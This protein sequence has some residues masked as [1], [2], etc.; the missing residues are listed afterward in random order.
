[1]HVIDDLTAGREAYA[2]RA[3][4]A[5]RDLLSRADP[6]RLEPDDLR[7][8]STAAYL[9]GD[10]GL[11]VRSRQRAHSASIALGEHLAAARDAHDI[12]MVLAMNGEPA[13]A[14][15]W[16]ARAERLLRDEPEDS[17]ER[18]FLLM[19]Q[20]LRYLQAGDLAHLVSCCARIEE[21]G[22]H[23]DNPDLVT[24]ALSAT[25]RA[26]LYA[27]KVPDGL[28]RLDEAM[29][30]LTSDQVSPLMAGQVY[31]TMIEGCQEIADYRRMTEWTEALTQW[32][33]DQPDLV[34][35]TGQCAVHRGQIHRSHG[36]FQAALDELALALDRYAAAGMGP[37][38]GLVHY[39]RGEVLRTLGDLDGAQSAFDDA[40]D[41]GLEPQPGQSLLWLARGRTDAAVS[42][43]HRLLEDAHDP[44][45]RSR[46][47]GAIVE[48]LCTAGGCEEARAPS[49]ELLSIAES[50]GC[51]GVTA[52]ASYAAGL[53]ALGADDDPTAALSHHR[54]AWKSWIALGARYDAARAR[55]QIARALSALGD[56]VSMRSE[57]SVAQRTFAELGAE[58]A[59]R[60]VEL[61]LTP[62]FPDGLTAREV[63]VLRLVAAGHSNPQIAA[64][65]VLSEKTVARHLSNIFGKT[66]VT[67]RTAAATYAHRHD[68]LG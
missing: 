59:R 40:A 52:S 15:G 12:A 56:T 66:G 3:W 28:A 37:A 16:V 63:E 14:S 57:L 10:R 18:G 5:A 47:L 49:A 62:E 20:V 36:E 53:V 43:A 9:T 44:V 35:F 2:R 31:C 65:L 19:H 42:S 51:D 25:G 39:E 41:F 6:E 64:A 54:R 67:S 22:R 23:H 50:F 4:A 13:V 11:A 17:V 27:G 34:P 46:R 29:V 55:V 60:A 1:M 58:P 33:A 21:I 45:T 24:Y 61:L 38:V 68:L 32:C 48:I 30:A 7:S 8:L 26:L